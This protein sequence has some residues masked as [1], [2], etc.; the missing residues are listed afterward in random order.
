MNFVNRVINSGGRFKR[1][2]P[3]NEDL[4]KAGL[5]NPSIFVDGEKIYCS[6]RSSTYSLYNISNLL[7]CVSANPGH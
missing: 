7:P 6:F 5:F 1:I 2:K 4:E 3:L